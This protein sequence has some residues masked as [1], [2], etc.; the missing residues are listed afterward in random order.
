MKCD[1]V[2]EAIELFTDAIDLD[3]YKSK[4]C[5]L[6]RA[7]AYKRIGELEKAYDDYKKALVFDRENLNVVR[8][9]ADCCY[10]LDYFEEAI[11]LYNIIAKDTEGDW[12]IS[13]IISSLNG[14][15]IE[16]YENKETRTEKE[17]F[18][19]VDCYLK[20]NEYEKCSEILKTLEDNENV[21]KEKLYFLQGKLLRN[22]G[23]NEEA[24]E[25]FDKTLE[26]DPENKEIYEYKANILND[27]NRDEEALECY[28]KLIGENEENDY[29]YDKM[30]EILYKAGKYEKS[31]E[32][33]EKAISI[34]DKRINAYKNKA[35]ILCKMKKYVTR[36]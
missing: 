27:L 33:C 7:E 8:E 3:P 30:A 12:E 26:I 28:K 10:A 15:L 1:K 16:E 19:L 14:F 32:A 22:L 17:N 34:N 31:L 2:E 25:Y 35:K 23:R 36:L 13:A 9:L 21:E 20:A 11:D 5:Y 18:Y 24:L 6:K 4:E 29:V